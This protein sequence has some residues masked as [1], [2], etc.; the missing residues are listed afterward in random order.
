MNYIRT[1][2]KVNVSWTLI[3]N[4][5]YVLCQGGMLAIIAKLGNAEMVGQFS[6][7][8]AICSPVQTFTNLDLRIMQASDVKCEYSFSDYLFTRL[9]FSTIGFIIIVSI[10]SFFQ[11]SLETKLVIISLG[12]TKF[13]DSTSDIFH[14]LMQKNERMD[15]IAISI[16]IK[17]TGSL[18]ALTLILMFNGNL[19]F[20]IIGM[21]FVNICIL[22]IFDLR[23][24]SHFIP[25]SKAEHGIVGIRSAIK[26]KATSCKKLFTLAWHTLP[27]GTKNLLFSLETSLPKLALEG[28][29]G[30]ASVGYFSAMAYI[31]AAGNFVVSALGNSMLP[32]LSQYYISSK[33]SFLLLIGKALVVLLSMILAG[34][35]IVFFFGDVILAILFTPEFSEYLKEFHYLVLIASIGYIANFFVYP[36]TVGRYLKALT[37]LAFF[38][39]T[40]TC[41][42]CAY[43]IPLN[44]IMGAV[45][46][47]GAATVVRM[48][49]SAS[50]FRSVLNK[51][52]P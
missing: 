27:L 10:I 16:M 1:S 51:S 38:T 49:V 35:C 2:L 11:C 21:L 45:M 19:F 18:S 25:V 32:R 17:G 12:L 15:M 40:V 20:G 5:V 34:L 50:M 52:I 33:R 36:I 7:G 46:A 3:G 24:G 43:F 22:L 44:G 48:F 14:G 28:Y 30:L 37:I 13:F 29:I 31:P 4:I 47:V 42:L 41:T 39:L 23:N 9:T 6:I 8:L 26:F